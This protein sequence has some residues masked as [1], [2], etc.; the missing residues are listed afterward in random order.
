MVSTNDNF[1]Q[2]C[3]QANCRSCKQE[4]L[5]GVLDL[6]I[7]PLSNGLLTEAQLSDSEGKFP[8]EVAY[9]PKCSL[10]QILETVPPEKL[11]C[12]DY[13]YYSSFSDA[14]LEHS[15]QNVLSLIQ[16]CKLDADSLVVELASNDGYLLRYYVENG[17]PCLGIDPAEGPAKS[18][19]K[20]GVTTLCSFFTPELAQQLA[21]DGRQADVIHANN[22]LAHVAD[23]NGF[24]QGIRIL[25]KDEG[26]A[27]IEVP[28][29]KDLID[30]C[31]FDT[32][33]HEHLCY[34]SV[35][36]LDHLF[37]QNGL[38]LND[39]ERLSIHGGSLRLYVARIENVQEPVRRL[40]TQE[41]QLEVDKY[42]YYEDF[43]N[44]IQN[45]RKKMRKLLHSTKAQGKTI[46]AYGAAAKGTIML[47]F[48]G[49]GP[50]VIDYVVDRNIHKQGKYMPGMHIPVCDPSRLEKELPDYVVLLPWN[51]KDEIL[52]QEAGYRDKGGKFVIPIPEPVIV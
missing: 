50:D 28:Y 29:V 51:F 16:R 17:I 12:E 32:I 14:L 23:T 18:A 43:S 6:G 20:V 3:R 27:V 35:T 38:Y 30:H 25:L 19:E 48:I 36:A 5:V 15:R 52:I 47:N 41:Q 49:I 37:H 24:I 31:E 33:Y 9:C 42:K 39:I 13:P 2:R 44:K 46:A 11:F 45:F 26:V 21:N 10:V 4:G 22:V 1:E 40:L 8:L 7:I 34:F